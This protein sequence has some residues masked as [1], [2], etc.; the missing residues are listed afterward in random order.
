MILK[1]G[2]HGILHELADMVAFA[3]DYDE[4]LIQEYTNKIL[5][6]IGKQ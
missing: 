6:S 4:E 2:I 5:T 3:E 1:E